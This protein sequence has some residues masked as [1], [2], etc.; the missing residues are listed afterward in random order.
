MRRPSAMRERKLDVPILARVEGE[1]ALAL[2]IRG[3]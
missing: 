2:T 1:G 3:G